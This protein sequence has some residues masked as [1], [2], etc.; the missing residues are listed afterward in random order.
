VS[1]KLCPVGGC[2]WLVLDISC[3][4]EIE[5]LVNCHKFKHGKLYCVLGSAGDFKV[6]P[7]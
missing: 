6:R 7:R 3:A 4:G 5:S 2:G 1:A